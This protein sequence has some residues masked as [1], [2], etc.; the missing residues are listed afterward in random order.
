MNELC[1]EEKTITNGIAKFINDKEKSNAKLREDVKDE[2][3][4][5]YENFLFKDNSDIDLEFCDE[6]ESTS[7]VKLSNKNN[8]SCA[9]S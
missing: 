7:K 2:F 9:N 5:E 6:S 1:L 4:P 8:D 3:E